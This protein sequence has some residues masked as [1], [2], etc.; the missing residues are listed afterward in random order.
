MTMTAKYLEEL[1]T[2]E[3]EPLETITALQAGKIKFYSV[4]ENL[5]IESLSGKM[6]IADFASRFHFIDPDFRLY[7]LDQP[8]LETDAILVDVKEFKSGNATLAQ[9]FLRLSDDL[10]KIVLTPAQILRFCLKFSKHL[11]QGDCGTFFP[12]RIGKKYYCFYIYSDDGW[13]LHV[14]RIKSNNFDYWSGDFKDPG[15]PRVVIKRLTAEEF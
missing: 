4:I 13:Y 15:R 14:T 6:L 8:S 1:R 7:D 9:I 3:S 11:S 2:T 12:T 10:E 5:L